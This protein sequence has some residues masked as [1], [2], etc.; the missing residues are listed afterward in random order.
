[1]IHVPGNR[2]SPATLLARSGRKAVAAA[3]LLGSAFSAWAV[4]NLEGGP[5][6]NQLDLHPPVTKIA[7]A[8]QDL[9]YMMLYI[10]VVIFVAV[11]GVMFYSIYAHRKSKGRRRPISMSRPPSK[12]SGRSCLS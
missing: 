2:V 8:Q 5:A 9:H 11:F 7:A 10:C 3:L 1:M 12:S 6:V 4:N